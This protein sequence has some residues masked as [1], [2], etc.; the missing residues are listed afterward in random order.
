MRFAIT[1]GLRW[2]IIS[3]VLTL[4]GCT[5]PPSE[6]PSSI[7]QNQ[8]TFRPGKSIFVFDPSKVAEVT[9]LKDGLIRLKRVDAKSWIIAQAPEGQKQLDIR[10]DGPLLEHLLE[11]LQTLRPTE[12]AQT[13]AETAGLEPP[14]F[15]LR[16]QMTG[17]NAPTL[18]IQ[19]GIA[20]VGREAPQPGQELRYGKLPGKPEI[21]ILQGSTLDM[22]GKLGAFENLR[23]PTLMDPEL[24]A[25]EVAVEWTQTQAAAPPLVV[26]WKHEGGPWPEDAVAWIQKWA[27]LRIQHFID[28]PDEEKRLLASLQQTWLAQIHLQDR[29]GHSTELRFGAAEGRVLAITSAR[30]GHVF[31]LF[32]ESI[33]AFKR[34]S[35]R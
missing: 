19:I 24:A 12:A 1:S 4:C 7:W 25:D 30:A 29:F 23:M 6:S 11:S 16:L 21:A 32:P 10:A 5:V 8:I 34:L 9:L 15:A 27:H 14:R 20:P 13:S 26:H 17:K 33:L 2:T 31:E 35:A 18:E 3:T 22:L 28:N